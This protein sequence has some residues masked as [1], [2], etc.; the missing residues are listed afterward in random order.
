MGLASLAWAFGVVNKDAPLNP[1]RNC[2]HCAVETARALTAGRD[3]TRVDGSIAAVGGNGVPVLRTFLDTLVNRA[4]VVLQYLRTQAPTGVY[5][6]D[7]EDHAYNFIVFPTR[8]IVLIDS[9]QLT[10]R[11]IRTTDDFQAIVYNA[12]VDDAVDYDYGNP[13]PDE[14]GSDMDFYH[15]G[16]LHPNYF[17]VLKTTVHVG[18]LTYPGVGRTARGA[19][20]ID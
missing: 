2:M 11:K 1:D 7:A 10:F 14:D 9:N 13:P 3:P 20:T 4:T 19:Y 18:S 8:V 16:A 12:T 5:A 17:V 6:V 15:W